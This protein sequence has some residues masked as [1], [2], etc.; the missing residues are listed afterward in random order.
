MS[1][2]ILV[3]AG[4]VGKRH[5]LKLTKIFDDLIIIDPN[6]EAL[7]WCASNL[8]SKTQ[9]YTDIEK[10]IEENIYDL[11]ESVCVLANWGVDHSDSFHKL[12]KA[13][14]KK[15]YI[16]KPFADSIKKIDEINNFAKKNKINIVS[17]FQLRHSGLP[18]KIKNI[19]LDVLDGEPN[20]ISVS[21][22]ANCLVTNG[23]HYLDLAVSI[24]QS[25]PETVISSLNLDNINPR[26]KHLGFWDGSSS[27]KFKNGASL[28]ISFTNK[29][30]VRLKFEIYSKNGYLEVSDHGDYATINVFKRNTDEIIIDPRIIRTG[31][32]HY[33]KI[34]SIKKFDLSKTVLNL[35]LTLKED[36]YFFN[37]ERETIATK[38]IL[39]SLIA[40]HEK[41][42]MFLPILKENI[43]YNKRWPVS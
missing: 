42:L 36:K 16:E 27:W 3:G 33:D 32:A 40:N 8:N 37:L 39:G 25:T 13:K 21:G 14:V 34:N 29:S 10:F 9:T 31:Y 17:G 22:G 18:E 26:G 41:K 5:A 19:S 15:F 12:A 7:D 4:H 24:F 23:I 38:C 11:S 1:V 2:A 28:N 20:F 6:E 30:S 43:C 35:F